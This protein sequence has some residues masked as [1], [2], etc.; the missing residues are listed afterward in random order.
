[1]EASLANVSNLQRYVTA[2]ARRNSS[3]G[4]KLNQMLEPLLGQMR[5]VDSY[6]ESQ[7]AEC[8]G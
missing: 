6:L 8:R 5:S 3:M 2:I 1:M 4:R 7:L